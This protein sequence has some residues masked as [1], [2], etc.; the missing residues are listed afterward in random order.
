MAG[1]GAGPALDPPLAGVRVLD[2][3]ENLPGPFAGLILAQLGATVVKIE[4]PGGDPMRVRRP[5]GFA[6]I[7][8][9][10]Q[11]LT[12]DLK[13]PRGQNH[14]L[15]LAAEADV[16]LQSFRPGVMSRL[17]LGYDQVRAENPGII[18]LSMSSYGASGP[19]GARAGHDQDVAALAGLVSLCG[20][21]GSDLSYNVGIPASDNAATLYAVI[22][23]LGALL[24]RH[25][26][27]G[28]GQHLDL[29]M[30]DA[31]LA[32]MTPRFGD[33]HDRPD[34]DRRD[35]VRPGSGVY[36]CNDG[37]FL[38]VAAVEQ[39]F[40]ALLMNALALTEVEDL[41]SAGWEERSKAFERID[42]ALDRR[43]R[44]ETRS[45]WLK[46]LEEA[47][48][49][50]SPVQTLPEVVRDT[51]FAAR[52]SFA[53]HPFVTPRFPVRLAGISDVAGN[54][55]VSGSPAAGREGTW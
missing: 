39:H 14:A 19:L 1:V 31:L 15:R 30:A 27:S 43:F 25:R 13:D 7:N 22:A 34:L 45:H 48:I 10:K 49:P 5:G 8:R 6:A 21:P 28:C 51:H 35:L 12:L 33:L 3:T 37:T 55:P 18:Y 11:S 20:R 16:L 23:V 4:R 9:G 17:G 24:Q 40:W 32:A 42:G 36:R 41:W 26:Q 54:E 44:Q 2:F 29:A 38:A 50:A 46:L 47:G 53:D 52:G